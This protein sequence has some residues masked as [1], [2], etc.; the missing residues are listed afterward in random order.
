MLSKEHL[1]A[2]LCLQRC[3]HLQQKQETSFK[4]ISPNGIPVIETFPYPSVYQSDHQ[5]TAI[6]YSFNKKRLC[7][8]DGIHEF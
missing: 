4:H 1:P 5:I 3:S 7:H 6:Q 2:L 8:D